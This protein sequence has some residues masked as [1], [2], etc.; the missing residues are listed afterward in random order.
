MN[1]PGGGEGSAV[2]TQET[3]GMMAEKK[4]KVRVIGHSSSPFL[5]FTRGV[6]KETFEGMH[7]ASEYPGIRRYSLNVWDGSL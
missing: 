7:V 1:P 5:Y 2:F 4:G 6:F 3:D